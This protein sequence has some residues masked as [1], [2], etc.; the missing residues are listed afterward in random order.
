MHVISIVGQKGGTGKTT[1]AQC[2]A[3]AA[4]QHRKQSM[5]LDLDP[6][7]N[8]VNWFERRED[9]KRPTVLKVPPGRLAAAVQAAREAEIDLLVIDTPG[10]LEGVAMSAA[11]VASLVLIPVRPQINDLET[12]TATQQL[13]LSVG[14]R[15]SLCVLSDVPVAGK[16]HEDAFEYIKALSLTACPAYLSHR[17][18]YADAPTLGLAAQ[19]FDPEGKAA[20][21]VKEVYR[22][23]INTLKRFN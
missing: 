22:F 5:I 17:V 11:E 18:A 4:T 20:R 6:Q 7:T 8:A 19:E 9:K 10:K 3:V 14:G 1:L 16:R 15:P 2:L 21:E 13:L 12:L 23:T